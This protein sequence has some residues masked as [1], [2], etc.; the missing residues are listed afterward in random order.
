MR[1]TVIPLAAKKHLGRKSNPRITGWISFISMEFVDSA[2]LNPQAAIFL[3][4]LFRRSATPKR[5]RQDGWFRFSTGYLKQRGI[6]RSTIYRE[7]H[8]LERLKLI[9]IRSRRGRAT[10]IHIADRFF[11]ARQRRVSLATNGAGQTYR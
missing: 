11:G 8:R 2:R 10:L 9:K 6:A 3:E 7:L 5:E 1:A 4:L